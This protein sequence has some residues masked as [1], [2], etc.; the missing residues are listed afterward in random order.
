MRQATGFNAGTVLRRVLGYEIGIRQ[1]QQLWSSEGAVAAQAPTA[2]KR[3]LGLGTDPAL[4]VS[5]T[6]DATNTV[7]N[8]IETNP[9]P[10]GRRA[11]RAANGTAGRSGVG[12][13]RG[14]RQRPRDR[15][16][17][18]ARQIAVPTGSLHLFLAGPLGLAVLLGHH[19]NRVMP[20][21]VY[22]HLGATECVEAFRISA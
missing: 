12:A 15:H 5:V 17:R 18:L 4:V 7:V 9:A 22:E 19:W 6:T 2:H 11:H 1:G 21:V 13:G 3:D 16:P 14:G 20:T 8:S 10:R